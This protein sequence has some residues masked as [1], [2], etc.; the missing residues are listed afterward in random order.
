MSLLQKGKKESSNSTSSLIETPVN[1][2]TNIPTPKEKVPNQGAFT[3]VR[4][5]LK[6]KDMG[7]PAV[8]KLLLDKRDELLSEVKELKIY[9]KKYFQLDKDMAVLK[10]KHD[11]TNRFEKLSQA[12]LSIGSLITGIAFLFENN[13]TKIITIVFGVVLALLGILINWLV[14]K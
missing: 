13:L 5:H 7:D 4:R 9:Q 2:K 6:D 10:T 14:K 11:K 3:N 1:R 8:T 12:C